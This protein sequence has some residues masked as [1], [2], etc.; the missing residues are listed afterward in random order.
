MRRQHALIALVVCFLTVLYFISPSAS[1]DALQAYTSFSFSRAVCPNPLVLNRPA[2]IRNPSCT[3]LKPHPGLGKELEVEL[4][5]S[6]TIPNHGWFRIERPDKQAC[7]QTDKILAST[8]PTIDAMLKAKGPDFFH[9][10]FDGEQRFVIETDVEYLGHCTYRYPFRLATAA[11]LNVSIWWPFKD[12]RAAI[13]TEELILQYDRALP[14]LDGVYQMLYPDPSA[15]SAAC[16]PVGAVASNPAW[17]SPAL[18]SYLDALP[19]CS[20]YEP[21][22][23]V[24]VRAHHSEPVESTLQRYVYQPTGCRW[25]NP[26]VYG[27]TP[28]VTQ[29]GFQPRKVLFLGDSHA[30]YAY[31]ILM[32]AYTGN[33]KDFISAPAMKKLEKS[34]ELGPATFDFAW[35]PVLGENRIQLNCST[36]AKYDTVVLGGGQH[37]AVHIPTE[38]DHPKQWHMD[39]WSALMESFARRLGPEACPGQKAPRVV[40]MGNPARVIRVQPAGKSDCMLCFLLLPSSLGRCG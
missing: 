1:P 38:K 24:Y 16:P 22:P 14:V 27:A 32:D 7:S 11:P 13:E 2:T 29:R 34:E 26:V 35:E 3:L 21:T 36:V 4:C 31:D 10:Q 30:R 25:T 37:N 19:P 6:R 40:W 9:I 12:Y 28:E 5:L 17:R 23:G 20:T 39:D 15:A 8:D 33:W 18:A